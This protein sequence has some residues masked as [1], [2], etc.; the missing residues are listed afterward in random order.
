M[1]KQARR[2]KSCWLAA[3][4][5]PVLLVLDGCGSSSQPRTPTPQAGTGSV[6]VQMRDAPLD[7]LVKFEIKVTG[8][9]LNSAEGNVQALPE[10]VEIELTSLQLTNRVIRLATN[11]PARNY[12]GV[13]LTFSEPEIEY[14]PDPPTPCNDQTIQEA[15][16]PLQ[17]GTVTVNTNLTVEQDKVIGLLVDFDLQA[18]V[19]TDAN[20]N[21]TAINPTL[22]V[23]VQN[24]NTEAEDEFE[25]EGRVVSIDTANSKF[26]FEPFGSCQQTEISANAETQFENF[27]EQGL[28]N[29]FSSLAVNQVLEVNG[30][31]QSD[32]TVRAHEV[33][34]EEEIE[35]DEA[36]GIVLSVDTGAGQFMLVWHE[37]APCSAT[38]LT[39]DII[40]VTLDPNNPP[41]FDIDEDDLI[42]N[43][44]LFSELGD[45]TPGQHVEV[46]GELVGLNITAQKLQLE[47]QTIRGT[48]TGVTPP[49]NFEFDP[50]SDLFV[51]QSITVETSAQT[52]FEGVAGVTSLQAGQEIRVKGLLFL[53]AGELLFVAKQVEAGP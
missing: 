48:V 10:P 21:I 38:G 3:L 20:G 34:L 32:G 28:A 44:D 43:P 19:V 5:I 42:V 50:A 53:Q 16:P 22:L 30:D 29:S 18:S 33:E 47:E 4:L 17:N 14:C 51:D 37:L 23:S 35:T 25:E 46:D 52:G 49:V 39:G 12:T 40:T 41:Q 26:V 15:N 11:I 31:I 7:N 1:R 36:E 27:D 8:I 6:L 9:Q 13:T 2:W 45:L 24:L